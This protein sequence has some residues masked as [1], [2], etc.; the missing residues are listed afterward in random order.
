M[1]KEVAGVRTEISEGTQI[2]GRLSGAEDVLVNGRIDGEVDL[3]GELT[4]GPEGILKADVN[5]TRV[6]VKGVV[7]GDISASES[8]ALVD[9]CK[10]VGD[11]RAP[12]VQITEGAR[13][14]GGLEVGDVEAARR[15]PPRMLGRS[16]P[17]MPARESKP[18]PPVAEEA[19]RPAKTQVASFVPSEETGRKKRVVKKRGR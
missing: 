9:G 14:S 2:R 7:A 5:A 19:P 12:V 10:V 3:D 8:V 15:E 18:P 1:S 11:V 4:V 6:V 13:F 16:R 17:A